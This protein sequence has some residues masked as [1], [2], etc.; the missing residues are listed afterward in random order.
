[1]KPSEIK[2]KISIAQREVNF[3]QEI[4][5]KKSCKDCEQFSTGACKLAGGV[6]PPAEIQQV[7]CPEWSWDSIPF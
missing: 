7:G 1:M 6:V 5:D 4:L 3:W 2:V